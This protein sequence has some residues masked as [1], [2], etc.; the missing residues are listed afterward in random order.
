M[1]TNYNI[2]IS[3]QKVRAKR[4][5]SAKYHVSRQAEDAARDE[6]DKDG[7]RTLLPID[8]HPIMGR[9]RSHDDQ[10]SVSTSLF[11]VLF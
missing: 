9:Q 10:A 5:I 8:E 11:N 6:E 3:Y 7:S 1:P 2:E 4:I